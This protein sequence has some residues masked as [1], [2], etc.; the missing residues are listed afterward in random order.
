[1]N[2][3]NSHKH[4][5]KATAVIEITSC[6]DYEVVGETQNPECALV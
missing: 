6:Q 2:D 3:I 1:M 4:L 5:S